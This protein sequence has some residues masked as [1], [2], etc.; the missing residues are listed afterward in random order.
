MNTCRAPHLEM[1]SKHSTM[2]T[3]YRYT[4]KLT[5]AERLISRWAQST[6]QWQLYIAIHIYIYEQLSSASSRDELKALH[7]GNYISQYIYIWTIVERLISRWAQSTTQWQLYIA[8]LYFRAPSRPTVFHPVSI[9]LWMSGDCSFTQRVSNIHLSGYSAVW[10]LQGWCR[11][12]LQP[13][14]RTFC[15]YHTAMHQLTLSLCCKPSTLG[16]CMCV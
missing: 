7:N 15:V 14:R 8:I 16:G 12:K 13:S 6:S 3:I 11:V 5:L 4:Y 9:R 1:S 2:A 10:L